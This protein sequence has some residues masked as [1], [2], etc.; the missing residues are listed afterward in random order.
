MEQH[1]RRDPRR[2]RVIKHVGVD[3]V[4]QGR[5]VIS[6]REPHGSADRKKFRQ[7]RGE[8]IIIKRIRLSGLHKNIRERHQRG[9]MTVMMN[10]AQPHNIGG[11]FLGDLTEKI[12]SVQPRAQQ[13]RRVAGAIE[14]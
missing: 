9:Q 11:N 2:I 10:L 7:L 12:Y 3:A 8:A 5:P 14:F 6:P 1:R 13:Y 4:A